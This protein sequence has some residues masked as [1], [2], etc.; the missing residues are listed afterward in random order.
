MMNKLTDML[1]RYMAAYPA[2]RIKPVGSEGSQ[3]REEQERLM[4][5]EEE[6]AELLKAVDSRWHGKSCGFGDQLHQMRLG[7][8]IT[9]NGK[10]LY[11]FNWVITRV[12]GGWIY[13]AETAMS[14]ISVFVPFNEEYPIP[15]R[16]EPKP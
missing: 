1:G 14:P 9:D 3:A 10:E 13:T 6:A 2:F 16:E 11:G 4:N 12:P 5:L 7:E 15:F 8:R